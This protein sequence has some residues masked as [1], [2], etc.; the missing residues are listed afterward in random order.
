MNDPDS[1]LRMQVF[2]WLEQQVIVHGK[3]LPRTLL[4]QGARLRNGEL[5]HLMGPQGIFKP[6]SFQLPLSVTT[7]PNSPYK[8]AFKKDNTIW[9]SF[10]G[11]DPN[12]VD[13]VGLIQAMQGVVPL[14]Y[15]IGIVP[16]QYY[17]EWPVFV[18]NADP[19]NLM[20][21]LQA[22]DKLALEEQ[23]FTGVQEDP[24]ARRSYV[25]STIRRRVHQQDFRLRVLRAYRDHCAICR[26]RHSEL[27][28][29]AHII[30]DRD[31]EGKPI[32][33]NGLSLCKLHHAA[34]DKMVLGISPD[35]RVVI[36]RDVLEEID[37]PMLKH[38]LVELHGQPIVLPSLR[39]DFPAPDR[40]DQRFQAF[41][42][43]RT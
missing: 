38:G 4:S 18:V 5:I 30:P 20:F 13:N 43:F 24:S 1:L 21:T 28:D 8:D 35:Y 15:F 42:R 2:E 10:R 17:V 16:G 3:V 34:F 14:I 29:A 25:T 36:R 26:L 39:K 6:R 12:H 37:G 11:S 19:G 23:S 27:L 40:L 9:Y 41:L 31:P 7:S 22:D 32:V 33:P